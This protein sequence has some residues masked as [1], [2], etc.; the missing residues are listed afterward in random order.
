MYNAKTREALKRILEEI[1]TP[2]TIW[3]R[4]LQMDD[5]ID[6][7]RETNGCLITY[8]A[9][10]TPFDTFYL[11]LQRFKVDYPQGAETAASSFISRL[12]TESEAAPEDTGAPT[13]KKRVA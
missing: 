13:K 10:P 8:G 9:G 5:V 1:A 4:H 7:W 3:N 12:E 6:I 11:A 2:G